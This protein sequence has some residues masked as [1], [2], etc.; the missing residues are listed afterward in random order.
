MKPQQL[1]QQYSSAGFNQANRDQVAPSINQIARRPSI[2]TDLSV[3]PPSIQRTD[4]R[5]GVA[6]PQAP[7]QTNPQQIPVQRPIQQQ[8]INA[9]P[10]FQPRQILQQVIYETRNSK[11]QLKNHI[12]FLFFSHQISSCNNNSSNFK[13]HDQ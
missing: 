4:S 11:A 2:S 3:G 1:P 12:S 10:Q 13:D 5:I 8:Q 6:T 9:Q 7:L